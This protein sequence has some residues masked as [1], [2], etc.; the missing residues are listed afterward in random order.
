MNVSSTNALSECGL[1]RYVRM[2]PVSRSVLT[3]QELQK[4]GP[5]SIGKARGGWPPEIHLVAVGPDCPLIL[6]LSP[7][8]AHDGPEGHKLIK[9]LRKSPYRLL[10]TDGESI[11]EQRRVALR[12]NTG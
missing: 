11:V 7:G 5:Q 6:R 10:G 3:G 1:K 2:D 4:R 9:M 8:N 12:K